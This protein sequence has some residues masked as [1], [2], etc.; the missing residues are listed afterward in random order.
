[1]V[2]LIYT[3]FE[4]TNKIAGSLLLDTA[5]TEEEAQ[6]KME[7]YKTRSDTFYEEFPLLKNGTTRHTYIMWH[8]P[9]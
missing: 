9:L 4:T 2:Y 5:Q 8:H 3:C 6:A 1:M 7:M